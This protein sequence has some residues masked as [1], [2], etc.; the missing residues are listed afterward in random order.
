[1]PHVK[2]FGG[3]GGGGVSEQQPAPLVLVAV[4]L[5]AGDAVAAR[6]QKVQDAGVGGTQE[7]LHKVG[8][9]LLHLCESVRPGD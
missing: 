3:R 4:Y 6:Q 2:A 9:L 8:V 7:L 1:M 5:L